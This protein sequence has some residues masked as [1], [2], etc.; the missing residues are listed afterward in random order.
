MQLLLLDDE[1]ANLF[2]QRSNRCLLRSRCGRR[3]ISFFDFQIHFANHQITHL[4]H[5]F[6]LVLVNKPYGSVIQ[7]EN[8]QLSRARFRHKVEAKN[9]NVDEAFATMTPGARPGRR[10]EARGTTTRGTPRPATPLDATPRSPQTPRPT[11]YIRMKRWIPAPAPS[12]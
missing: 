4:L 6:F 9:V 11:R 2:L 1:P 7:L 5:V 3:C 10:A 12:R 8:Y